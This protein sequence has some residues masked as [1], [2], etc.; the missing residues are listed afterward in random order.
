MWRLPDGFENDPQNL[1]V[2]FN[3][4]NYIH[5]RPL[6]INKAPQQKLFIKI[7]FIKLL[8]IHDMLV[9]HRW[10]ILAFFLLCIFLIF[11]FL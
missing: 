5:L 3:P 11:Y 9:Y 7:P 8:F 2:R 4:Y 1:R 6:L 10:I